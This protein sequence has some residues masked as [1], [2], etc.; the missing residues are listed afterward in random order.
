MH[1]RVHGV[2]LAWSINYEVGLYMSHLNNTVETGRL[3]PLFVLVNV[4]LFDFYLLVV[5]ILALDNL[6]NKCVTYKINILNFNVKEKMLS[7]F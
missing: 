5:N 6:T 3:I 4:G 1:H 2:S 7:A